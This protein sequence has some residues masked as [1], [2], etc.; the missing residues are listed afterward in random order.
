MQ[1]V[2]QNL[3][4]SYNYDWIFRKLDYTFK[5]GGSYAVTGPNGS[6]KSTLLQVLAGII[7]ESEGKHFY[8]LDR[9]YQPEDYYKF[10]SFASP[11]LELF[12]ELTL[13]EHLR[14]HFKLKK[15]RDGMPHEEIAKHLYLED[16]LDKQIKNYSSGMKQRLKLGLALFSEVPITFLDE[17]TS[18]L[19]D[20]G[21]NWYME[22][23]QNVLNKRI[24]IVAS[25][26]PFEYSFCKESIVIPDYQ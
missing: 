12:E 7:P 17:P 16:A 24:L 4:K 1:I 11:Y 13:K 19:D 10:I 6:G 22:Q 14:F 25:N 23:I 20:R 5:E 3:G 8:M 2:V 18:N 15:S 9:E 21:K 26:N